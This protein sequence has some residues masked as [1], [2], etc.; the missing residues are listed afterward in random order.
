MLNRLNASNNGARQLLKQIFSSSD[1]MAR[2][3][4]KKTSTS[5]PNDRLKPALQSL[6]PLFRRLL[7]SHK[8][9]KYSDA[10][11]Q[12]CFRTVQQ[13][14]MADDPISRAHDQPLQQ[15]NPVNKYPSKAADTLPHSKRQRT[16]VVI[17]CGSI[18]SNAVTGTHVI[19]PF[20]LLWWCVV[21]SYSSVQ[22]E[23]NSVKYIS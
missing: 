3:K 15:A 10:L 14:A 2:H 17:N 13:Q 19:L 1:T 6:I 16:G 23:T 22:Q 9:C 7:K 4:P 11:E 8:C 20:L 21:T 18:P 5:K 12:T